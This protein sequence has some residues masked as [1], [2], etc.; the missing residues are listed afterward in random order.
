MYGV[1]YQ[2]WV[3]ATE[4]PLTAAAVAF[5]V[6][7][8]IQIISRPSGL[9][10]LIAEWVIWTSWGLFLVDYV[11]RFAVVEHRGRWFMRHLLDPAIVIL[12]MLRPLRLMRF[13][14]VIALIQRSAGGILRGRII[15]YTIG[16]SMVVILISSLAVLDAERGN[17]NINNFGDAVWW[18]FVSMT[19]VGYGEFHPVTLAGR[20]VAAGLM[21]AGVTLIGAVTATLASWIVERVNRETIAV[22][23]SQQ[24]EQLREELAEVRALLLERRDHTDSPSD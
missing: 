11:V 13:L 23:S 7:Y 17:G 8:A 20:I 24:V 3:K 22:A 2:R 5:F 21:V 4:W 14:T 10:A 15:V 1:R 19:T 12:P 6:A 16:A 18:T 9:M